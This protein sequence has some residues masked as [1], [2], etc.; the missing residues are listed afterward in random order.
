MAFQGSFLF[1]VLISWGLGLASCSIA[2][3]LGCLVPNV[4]DVS[5][6]APLVYIPQ[7]L[8]AGFFIRTS[9][10]PIFLRW[11]QYLCGLKYAI[12]L[13][14]LT[15]FRVDSDP[16]NTSPQARKNCENLLSINDVTAKDFSIYILL[17][18]VLFLAF[19]IVGGIVLYYKAKRFY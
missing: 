18:I 10:I 12:N 11:S 2:M 15:E 5:E 17:L 1:L 14:L 8:F 16:C 19:R 13:A 6:L 4:K 7:L 3:G 9:Q